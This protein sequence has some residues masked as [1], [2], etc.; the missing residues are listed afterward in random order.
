MASERR[1]LG[2]H[3]FWQAHLIGKML[4][5]DLDLWKFDTHSGKLYSETVWKNHPWCQEKLL[6]RQVELVVIPIEKGNFRLWKNGFSTQ[7]GISRQISLHITLRQCFLC[8]MFWFLKLRI[9]VMVRLFGTIWYVCGEFQSTTVV[10]GLYI[11]P[12]ALQ[13][14]VDIE[15]GIFHINATLRLTSL[16][17]NQGL[18]TRNSHRGRRWTK[19]R[20]ELILHTFIWQAKWRPSEL[21]PCLLWK[22]RHLDVRI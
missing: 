14:S 11:L 2:A 1:K 13:S 9:R 22:C 6:S 21:I 19:S 4:Y 12:N 5:F 8:F 17:C 10:H 20:S 3:L 18:N 15:T 16:G 7:G